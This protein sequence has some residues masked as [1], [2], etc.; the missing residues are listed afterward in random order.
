MT[1]YLIL[2]LATRQAD[3]SNAYALRENSRVKFGYKNRNIDMLLHSIVTNDWVIFW[4][5]RRRVDGYLRAILHFHAE[6]LRKTVLKAIGRSYMNCD[7]E[8]IL[9]S[10][11]DSELSWREL[12]EKEDVGWI[13]DGDRAI[14]RKPK[15]KPSQAS[16]MR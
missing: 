6:S 13:R 2:D 3:L 11:T 10:S 7:I 8:W 1:A 16:A 4:R 12:V 5:I 15:S 14:I 9:D